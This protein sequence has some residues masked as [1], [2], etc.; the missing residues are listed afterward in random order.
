[1]GKKVRRIVG[2]VAMIA[3]PFAA[4][5]V[6]AKFGVSS[7]IGKAMI[8]GVIGGAGSKLSGGGFTKGFATSALTTGISQ[9]LVGS[10]A[11]QA[12]NAGD[13]AGAGLNTGANAAAG[14]AVG[15]GEAGAAGAGVQG[16]GLPQAYAAGAGTAAPT[17]ASII[18]A[19][20]PA[21][22]A[23]STFSP[24]AGAGSTAASTAAATQ[25][26]NAFMN[27]LRAGGSAILN[28]VADPQAAARLIAMTAGGAMSGDGMSGQQR[29]MFEAARA[30]M[31]QLRQR[32]LQ[33]YNERLA[34]ARQVLAEANAIDPE[35][36]G[37]M[38]MGEM[39]MRVGR[40]QRQNQRA[41]G[42]RAGRPMDE[43]VRARQNQ[44]MG[45]LAGEAAFQGGQNSAQARRLAGL[46]TG[47]SMIPDAP[48]GSLN[49]MGAWWPALQNAEQN[50]RD[51]LEATGD[52]AETFGRAFGLWGPRPQ[53]AGGT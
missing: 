23:T 4:P 50:R 28:S 37:R 18:A 29:E 33:A 41:A 26:G 53:P 7:L 52:V 34:A 51:D 36:E 22:V 31:E 9:A 45:Q 42:L 48:Q 5:I 32:D 21:G 24:I 44:V 10:Q 39:Q 17:N 2:V 12:G 11:A 38:K 1:M 8:G 47:A 14:P 6:A 3:A 16:T 43:S 19:G 27:M 30:E 25:T 49:Q 40:Q 15:L 46:K 20:N 35:Q 13:V